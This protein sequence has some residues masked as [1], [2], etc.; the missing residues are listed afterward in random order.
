MDIVV[1]NDVTCLDL[2]ANM[3]GLAA[4]GLSTLETIFKTTHAKFFHI[5][6]LGY[7]VKIFSIILITILKPQK[8]NPNFLFILAK[9]HALLQIS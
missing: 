2:L 4:V 1:E 8:T 7:S 9:L 3:S 6:V 5:L